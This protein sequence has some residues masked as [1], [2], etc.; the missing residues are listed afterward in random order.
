MSRSPVSP[1]RQVRNFVRSFRNEPNPGKVE[2][3]T[4]VSKEQPKDWTVL[5]YLKGRDRLSN[6]VDV[7]LNGMEEIGSTDS[8]NIVAQATLVPEFGDRRFQ[9]MGE[10]NTRR[11]YIQNDDDLEAVHSPVVHQYDE[12]KQ[13]NPEN[14]EDFLTWGIKQFPAKHFAVVV[15]KHGL[16]FAANG[17]SVPIS[18][19]EMRQTLE[20]VEE[21]TGIKP[22]VLCWDSCNMQQWEVAYELK[23]RTSVMTGSPEAIPAVE[24]PY[25][26]LLHNLVRY[27][28]QQDAESLGKTVIHSYAAEAPQT[29]QF[30]LDLAQ[31]GKVAAGVRGFVDSAL[32]AGVSPQRLYTNLMKSASFQ[33]KESLAL[34]YNFRDVGGFLRLVSEDPEITSKE[35]KKKAAEALKA[36]AGAQIDG[37]VSPQRAHLKNLSQ[38]VGPSAFL[39]W[40]QPSEKLRESYSQLAWAKDTGWDRFLD[41]TLNPGKA[42]SEPPEL[43]G[44][45]AKRALHAYKKYVS[46]YLLTDCPY[47]VSCSE[48]AR[49]AL[50]ELGTW[51]G[52]KWAAMRLISCQEGAKGGADHPPG[53]EHNHHHHQHPSLPELTLVPPNSGKKSPLRKRA[54]NSLFRLARATGKLVGGSVAALVGGVAGAVAGSVWGARAGAGTLEQRNQRLSEKYGHDKVHSLKK[55]QSPLSKPGKVVR[56]GVTRVAGPTIG[57]AAGAVAGAISGATLGLLGGGLFS[58]RFFGGFA[59]LAAQNFVKDKMGELPVHYHT[60]QILQTSYRGEQSES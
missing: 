43:E 38:D 25:P 18:A 19:R 1:L 12:H 49:I 27:P 32:E 36:M 23:D 45:L 24:Y 17:S 30:A 34:A 33:P 7:A 5:A 52:S 42:P 60:E 37:N 54:E 44:G 47:D 28:Q 21:R 56:E 40:K 59:G 9:S 58:Y 51:E 26:T 10:V 29:T 2:P 50:K 35:V 11:Y 31:M 13:L 14:L 8:V 48:Y 22:E 6:S 53:H 57:R 3:H 16:G 55:L 39:P 4:L 15:K 41:Y 20:R 46:P